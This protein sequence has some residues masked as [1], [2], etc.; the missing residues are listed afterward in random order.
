MSPPKKKGG[1]CSLALGMGPKRTRRKEEVAH[2]STGRNQ[3]KS[4]DE[5]GGG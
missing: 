3:A 5:E 1:R 2:G 4:L